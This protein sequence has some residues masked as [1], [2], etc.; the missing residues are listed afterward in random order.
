MHARH[1]PDCLCHY[2]EASNGPFRSLSVLPEDEA[3]RLMCQIR[4]EGTSFTSR[5]SDD[6]PSIRR[7]L[8]QQVRALFIENGDTFPAMRYQDGRPY[9]GQVYLLAE[10]DFPI[11]SYGLPQL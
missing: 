10:L 4:E 5:R 7:G 11:T 3:E 2:Y 6:Y 1:L 8:E 9:R